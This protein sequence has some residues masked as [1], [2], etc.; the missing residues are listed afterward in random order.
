MSVELQSSKKGIF[1]IGDVKHF[2]ISHLLSSTIKIIRTEK[3]KELPEVIKVQFENQVP[4]TLIVHCDGKLLPALAL[5]KFQIITNSKAMNFDFIE[6][7]QHSR[8]T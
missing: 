7:L 4:D 1:L 6:I 8:T 2:D 5:R 3:G